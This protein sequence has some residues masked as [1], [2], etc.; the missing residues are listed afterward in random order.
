MTQWLLTLGG[1]VAY[2]ESIGGVL[3]LP[4]PRTGRENF[5][6]PGFSEN[7]NLLIL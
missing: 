1:W 5:R 3:R 2:Y 4:L 6:F 7:Y